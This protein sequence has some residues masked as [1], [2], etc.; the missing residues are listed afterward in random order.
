VLSLRAVKVF[1]MNLYTSVH[2]LTLE[3]MKQKKNSNPICL[4]PTMG[5]LHEGHYSLVHEALEASEN[6]WVSIFVN[7]TQFNDNNDFI[8]YPK[9]L[10]KDIET[11]L[12]ISKNIKIFAP[13]AKEIYGKNIESQKFDFGYIGEVMEG[14]FRENH[15]NGVATIVTKLL[16]LFKPDFVFFG[17]K[18]FQQ[19]LIVQ[20][21]I[22][23][24][25]H[26]TNLV[27]CETI[28]NKNG[29]A[30][31]SRNK[32]LNRKDYNNS[33][34][35]HEMLVFSKKNL[36]KIPYKKIKAHITSEINK[37]ENFKLEYFEIRD[38]KTLFEIKKNSLNVGLRAFISVKVNSV[39][40]ID[41]YLL[42]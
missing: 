32:L 6:V 17:E 40:L 12:D 23:E 34:I 8:N 42:N 19:I 28:R 21:I 27:R 25:F 11:I 36:M 3:L 10:N 24:S 39:R 5:S 38:E 33:N 41:N 22:D 35:I 13:S 26:V 31:S 18:D 9:N 16:D 4:V 14:K 20:K 37:I 7:P 1:L 29:L 2:E 15:F 30:L